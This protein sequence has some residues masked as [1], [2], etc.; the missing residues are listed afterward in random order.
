MTLSI[1]TLSIMTLSM[2]GSFVTHNIKGSLLNSAGTELSIMILII[3]T[4][5]IMT[6]SIMSLSIDTRHNDT[7]YEGLIYYTQHKGS[8][9]K[10]A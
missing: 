5:S 9:S 10:S 4:L 6:I 7:Q 3:I 2:K 8:L 1:M